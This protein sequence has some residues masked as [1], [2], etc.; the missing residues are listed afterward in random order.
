MV[1]LDNIVYKL[2]LTG[3]RSHGRMQNK[4][5]L[6][7]EA[8]KLINSIFPTMQIL[9]EVPINIRKNE[10]L[11]LDFYLPLT[12][13]CIEVHGEQHYKFI[14]FYHQN[15]MGFAKSK[16]RDDDK[17]QWCSINN[18]KQI[19]LPHNESLEQWKLRLIND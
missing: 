1:G 12:R 5:G 4:S 3:L 11:Y 8:R 16:K 9:E 17:S 6:H 15:M 19:I 18:I 13:T 14:K 2:N 7:L 10:V